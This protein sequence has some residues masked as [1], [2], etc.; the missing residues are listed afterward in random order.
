MLYLSAT[1]ALAGGVGL[2][3]IP[4]HRNPTKRLLQRG[5]AAAVFGLGLFGTMLALVMGG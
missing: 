1:A 4:H 2:A 3:M 5:G